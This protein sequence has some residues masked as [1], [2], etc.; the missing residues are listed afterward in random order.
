[1]GSGMES[2]KGMLNQHRCKLSPNVLISFWQVSIQHWS[3]NTA[4]C[5]EGPAPTLCHLTAWDLDLEWYRGTNHD[6]K[7]CSK[8]ELLKLVE[9]LVSPSTLKVPRPSSQRTH[10]KR[11]LWVGLGRCGPTAGNLSHGKVRGTL[12]ARHKRDGLK[13]PSLCLAS[14][15]E[16]DDLYHTRIQVIQT[17]STYCCTEPYGHLRCCELRP[18]CE[19][20][21]ISC[22]FPRL[23]SDH[24]DAEI[25]SELLQAAKK[26]G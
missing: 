16:D 12:R 23:N 9:N 5:S 25:R 21:N 8:E 24:S 20:E 22:L 11:W 13:H 7:S 10:S 4:Q 17:R 19:L 14:S 15:S 26:P 18:G 1:M 6:W 2:W 3:W